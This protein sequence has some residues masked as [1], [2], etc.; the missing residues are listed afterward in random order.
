[1]RHVRSWLVNQAQ[2]PG[3]GAALILGKYLDFQEWYWEREQAA[4]S[5]DEDIREYPTAEVVRAMHD[6]KAAEGVA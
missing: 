4:G 3:I 2:A 5:S 6:W 1:V